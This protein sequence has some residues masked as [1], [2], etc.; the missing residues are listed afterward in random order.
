[1][2]SKLMG[3]STLRPIAFVLICRLFIVGYSSPAFSSGHIR[4][5]EVLTSLNRDSSTVR[6]EYRA[7][8]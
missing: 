5:Q 3:H 4:S 7:T 6:L 8:G 1:M 2:G